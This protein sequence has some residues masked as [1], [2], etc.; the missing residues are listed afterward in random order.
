MTSPD[1]NTLDEDH[2]VAG[3]NVGMSGTFTGLFA[4]GFLFIIRDCG[5]SNGNSGYC[6]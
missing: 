4:V 3:T 6:L 2:T 1:E 5:R